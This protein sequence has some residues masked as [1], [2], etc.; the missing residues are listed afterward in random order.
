MIDGGREYSVRS[1]LSGYGTLVWCQEHGTEL[2]AWQ[3]RKAGSYRLPV[4]L[5]SGRPWPAQI[6]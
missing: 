6:T 5:G 3:S 1:T 2:L 4:I